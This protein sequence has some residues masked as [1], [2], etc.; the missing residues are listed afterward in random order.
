[1][2]V[3][4]AVFGVSLEKMS[5]NSEYSLEKVYLYSEY[6]F[7]KMLK[8]K[9][10]GTLAKWKSTSGHKPLVIMGIRQCGKTFI[11]QHFAEEHYKTVVYIT[12]PKNIT[13]RWSI[14]LL[15]EN[16]RKQ[17]AFGGKNAD[18]VVLDNMP[19]SIMQNYVK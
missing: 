5:K 16:P 7:K 19:Y 17:V 18:T 2:L 3:C 1:M 10:E 9:I 8:R 6:S 15:N 14:S 13:R 11:A 12:L 4:G